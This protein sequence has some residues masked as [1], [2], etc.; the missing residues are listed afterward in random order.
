MK[1]RYVILAIFAILM[2]S[3]TGFFLFKKTTIFKTNFSHGRNL[4]HALWIEHG[5]VVAWKVFE[6]Y[7]NAAKQKNRD[8]LRNY[9]YQ[10][11]SVCDGDEVSEECLQRM[12]SAYSVGST[13]EKKAFTVRYGDQ[14][15]FILATEPK[16]FENET[17]AGYTQ[18][19]LLFAKKDDGKFYVLGMDPDR[20]WYTIKKENI[21]KEELLLLA[22]EEMLD[23]DLD[24]APDK[25]ENCE[26]PESFLFLSCEKT[27]PLNRDTDQDGWWDGIE[28]FLLPR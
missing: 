24:G 23:S 6:Q 15:Q 25:F 1:K 3:A 21:S 16:E 7:L 10:L 22:K 20:S 4:Q 14:K 26:F 2:I 12:E 27:D 28:P 19:Y 11:S 17:S 13:F 9:S 5:D 8:A 18:Q